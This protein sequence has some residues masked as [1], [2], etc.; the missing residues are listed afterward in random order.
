M[1]QEFKLVELR[2]TINRINWLS[3]RCLR[4]IQVESSE[5]WQYEC[6]ERVF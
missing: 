6:V 4:D 1:S 3:G 5:R 2:N